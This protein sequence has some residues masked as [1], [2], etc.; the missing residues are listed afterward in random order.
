MTEWE[1]IFKSS[2]FDEPSEPAS[3]FTSLTSLD[4]SVAANDESSHGRIST[5]EDSWDGFRLPDN[6]ENTINS[7]NPTS[8][9][10]VRTSSPAGVSSTY[11]AA[12]CSDTFDA[13]N[14][15]VR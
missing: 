12:L 2:V 6:S 3:R 15:W 5:F 14:S 8:I 9:A 4:G 11:S 13:D 7:L 10:C 1:D